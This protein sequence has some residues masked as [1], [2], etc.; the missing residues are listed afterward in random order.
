[1]LA[2]KM[3]KLVFSAYRFWAAWHNYAKEM[4]LQN[5][6]TQRYKIS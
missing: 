2:E 3:N 6:A 1:M 5:K 4:G